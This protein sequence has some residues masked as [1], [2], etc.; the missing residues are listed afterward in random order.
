MLPQVVL[1]MSL[2]QKLSCLIPGV[3][4]SGV[5]VILSRHANFGEL[6]I[7][8]TMKANGAAPRCGLLV[9]DLRNGD[10]VHWFRFRV[11]EVRGIL[12][13]SCPKPGNLT[14]KNSASLSYFKLLTAY[15]RALVRPAAS[16]QVLGSLR[17]QVIVTYQRRVAILSVYVF[18]A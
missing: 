10:I 15:G 2:S 13:C 11:A 18:A 16:H 14:H 9:I 12:Q 5:T 7:N 6:P 17:R 8:A 4:S 3:Q 1:E